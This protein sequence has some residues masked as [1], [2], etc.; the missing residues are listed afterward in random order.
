[1]IDQ[2]FKGRFCGYCGIWIDGTYRDF[3]IHLNY[4]ELR[5]ANELEKRRHDK[6]STD[7]PDNKG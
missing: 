3:D 4:C 5:M 1:M 6:G 7:T 2:K